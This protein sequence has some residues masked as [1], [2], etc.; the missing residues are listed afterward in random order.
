M[1]N[2]SYIRLLGAIELFAKEHLQIKRFGSD[3]PGQMPNFATETEAYPILFVSPTETIFN[4]NTSTFQVD[5]YCFDIIQKDRENINTILSDTNLILSDLHRWLLDGDV[6]GLDIINT[7]ISSPINDGLLDYVAGWRTTLVIDCSTYGVCEIPFNEMPAILTE[8]NDIVYTSYLTCETL[9]ECDTFTGAIDNLQEQIDNI[10]LTPGPTGATG[11]QGVTGATGAKGETGP[12]GATGNMGATGSQGV[13]GATGAKG[14]TGPQGAT[15]AGYLQD[16]QDVTDY[17]NITTNTIITE[18]SFDYISNNSENYGSFGNVPGKEY[19]QFAFYSGDQSDDAWGTTKI[20]AE[21]ETGIVL[22]DDSSDGTRLG[23]I[24]LQEGNIIINSSV[25]NYQKRIRLDNDN[26]YFLVNNNITGV[27]NLIELY[28][29][30]TY[31]RKYFLTDEGFNGNYTQFN[32]AATEAGAV[33]KL[34]WNDTDGTLDLGLKGGNVTL[35]LGQELVKRV[36]NKTGANLLESEFKVVRVRSVAEGGAQGQR[37]AV[38][39]AQAN[40]DFNSAETLGVVTENIANNQEGFVTLI[41]QVKGINTTGAMSYGGLETWV[42]GDMLFLSPFYPGYMTNVKPVAPNHM[43]VIGYVEY[44]HAFNGKID[45][46]IQ[47]GYELDE[48][49]N[50]LITAATTGDILT[51]NDSIQVWEN[52]KLSEVLSDDLFTIE[53][54]DAQTVDF[55]APKNMKINSITNLVASPT[56]TLEVNSISYT[57]GTSITQGSKITVDVNIASVINLNVK[58]E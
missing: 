39:L 2:I 36:V 51:Y 5:V 20:F 18:A 27:S 23:E 48:L 55:Y 25:D 24:S 30:V 22:S 1:A 28:E 17:G 33:G 8:V 13:T 11:S 43:V 45:I 12:Q 32:T 6:Y 26:I 53:L 56:T 34:K 49:H 52:K 40:N 37:L 46:N 50:V 4:Q 14:E 47:N 42:D 41:G 29:N 21:P 3:F 35:Q 31:S 7:P 9:G 10:E 15:G 19:S 16:L 38:K 54:I 58:Y 57:L 44:A